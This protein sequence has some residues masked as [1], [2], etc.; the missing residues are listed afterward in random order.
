MNGARARSRVGRHACLL[1]VVATLALPAAWL[2]AAQSQV[3]DSGTGEAAIKLIKPPETPDALA[4]L[5]QEIAAELGRLEPTTRPAGTAPASQPA[6]PEG[7]NPAEALYLSLQKL[8]EKLDLQISLR[9]QINNLKS[10]ERIKAFSDELAAIQQRA[11]DLESK[12]AD[13]PPYTSEQDVKKA[14][15]EYEERNEEINSR[16]SLQTERTKALADA[17]QRRKD[18]AAAVQE[19]QTALRELYG[20]LRTQLDSAKAEDERHRIAQQM[21]KAELDAS[22]VLFDEAQIKLVEERDALLQGQEERRIATLRVLVAKL[23]D[24]KALLQRVQSRSEREQLQAQL[25]FAARHPGVSPQYVQSFWKLRLVE[26]AAREELAKRD[27]EMRQ[28]FPQSAAANLEQDLT[29]ERAAW[30]LFMDSLDRRPSDQIHD[31]Y[32]KVQ[33]AIN[34][35]RLRLASL[36]RTLDHTADDQQEIFAV[37]D[38]FDDRIAAGERLLN[39]ALDADLR[40][41]PADAGAQQISQQWVQV[42]QRYNDQAQ[43]ARTDLADLIKR[44]KTEAGLTASFVSDLD[45]YRSRL[46]WRYLVVSEEP[47]WRSRTELISAEWKAEREKRASTEIAL[48]A[49][50]RA[51]SRQAWIMVIIVAFC[52]EGLALCLRRVARRHIESITERIAAAGATEEDDRASIADRLHLLTAR[53]VGRAALL[54]LPA[55]G[56]AALLPFLGLHHETVSVVLSGLCFLA[57]AVMTEALVRATFLPGR[58]RQRLL[59]C[60]SV[61][62]A[63]YRRWAMVLWTVG[64]LLATEPLLLWSLDWAYDTRY[65]LWSLFR[66]AVLVVILIFGIQK[67]LVMRVTGRPE[68][69]RHPRLYGLISTLY[70]FIW[71]GV[72]ALFLLEVVGFGALVSYVLLACAATLATVLLAIL[73][74][75]YLTALLLRAQKTGATVEGAEPAPTGEQSESPPD[76]LAVNAAAAVLRWSIAAGAA[77][78]ILRYW[79]ITT[80]EVK[81]GLGYELVAADPSA[82]R[83]AMTLGRIL[84]AAVSLGAAWWAS[85]AIRSILDR[86]VYPAH[87]GL[88]RGARAAISTVLHYTLM[89]LGLYFSL[90]A[91]RVPLGALTVVLGTLGLG[92]GLGLQP[93][94][95][96]FISGL[97]ILFERHVRVGDLIVVNGELGEVTNLSMR[98]TSMRTPDGIK[99]VIPNSELITQN[100]INW[101]MQDTRL[102]ARVSVGVAYGTDVEL[103]KRLLMDILRRHPLVLSNPPPEVW[104]MAFGAS[105]LD[106]EMVGWFRNALERWRFMTSVRYETVRVFAEHGIEIPFPQQTLSTLGGNPLRVQ[107]VGDS[108]GNDTRRELSGLEES[109]PPRD[110]H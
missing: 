65:L 89:L 103:V 56:I 2:H 4:K 36:R 97:M 32:R 1:A 101:T 31:R 70:P 40:D 20:R 107:V 47:I 84:A 27:R 9:K 68:Q 102:R 85:R 22:L 11:R 24:W 72:C 80:V 37:L 73:A 69:V 39:E 79:G 67:R 6:A 58:P 10:P 29:A 64:I 25:D 91:M 23:G 44:L 13:P 99:F 62:A 45:Q 43:T 14:D 28:R 109:G 34:V 55:V 16:V 94:F 50:F 98:S 87:A 33:A 21:R 104:F 15:A 106:F 110:R 57:A 17:P 49:D 95:V 86:R 105:S 12:L 48:L 30:S 8:S 18:A 82:G 96:N 54:A 26:L 38:D 66:V 76:N 83:S 3:V 35:W 52:A 7:G 60:S 74:A 88:D 61:V 41:H 75:R 77:M 90:V 42:K 19:A 5:R 46:Y 63:Y 59:R 92:V 108:D 78:L 100:V 81:A 93:L 53:L 51:L 71:T